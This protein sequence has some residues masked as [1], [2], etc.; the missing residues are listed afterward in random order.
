MRWTDSR[1]RR[2]LIVPMLC[3]VAWRYA[4]L[5]PALA[6]ERSRT[7]T[8]AGAPVETPSQRWLPLPEGSSTDLKQQVQWL[9]QLKG[10]L[11]IGSAEDGSSAAP[12]YD[13]EQ[14]KAL[15][16]AMKPL[17]D[18]L[19]E[20]LSSRKLDGRSAEQLSKMMAD[21][22]MQEQVRRLLEQFS[23][24]GKPLPENAADSTGVPFPSDS[25]SPGAGAGQ[26][27]IAVPR[28]VQELM[29]RL[30]EQLG[31]QPNGQ[32]SDRKPSEGKLR[33]STL[34]REPVPPAIPPTVG[35]P[36]KPGS[37]SKTGERH[38]TNPF[39]P[40][41]RDDEPNANV[42]RS[43]AEREANAPESPDEMKRPPRL[44]EG[45]RKPFDG[46]APNPPEQPD[47]RDSRSTKPL[48]DEDDSENGRSAGNST[49][50]KQDVAAV[51]RA[52]ERPATPSSDRKRPSPETVR[53]QIP[54]ATPQTPNA[55]PNPATM[56]VRSELQEKGFAR[57]LR[58]IVEQARQESQINSNNSTGESADDRGTLK[59]S[60]RGLENSIVRM[61]DGFR[62]DLA[63]EASKAPVPSPSPGPSG[64]VA[65][66]PST[67][68]SR[69]ERRSTA[70]KV[71]ESIGNAFQEMA[72][73]P[74]TPRPASRTNGGVADLPA[75]GSRSTGPLLILLAALGLVW[76]FLP[77]MLTAF[78]K[79]RL[80][81]NSIG[82]AI[83][84]ADVRTREDVV[85]AFHKYALHSAMSAP[86]WWTHREVERR[87]SDT[88][89]AL[90]PS[91]QA[92]ANLYEQARYLPGDAEFT[93]DQLELARRV[94]A[95]VSGANH[96]G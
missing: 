9:L 27:P 86:T 94:L 26:E 48:L 93:P 38:R 32:P 57:T 88:A 78:Q 84:A 59:G 7:G 17:T 16:S 55:N 1:C 77:R 49:P 6:Q 41:P 85:R 12:P 79:S 39:G 24:T 62:K 74:A 73:A 75:G 50:G 29:K 92:L 96:L 53:P 19:P 51:P 90:R 22:A 34:D 47:P 21:P 30:T 8:S 4:E 80:T 66:Q 71:F 72:S 76:H 64:V 18:M 5:S 25:L 2:T 82:D 65:P 13:P 87:V 40:E 95:N 36:K 45:S 37:A 23:K 69:P 42:G 46:L 81:R 44:S 33:P 70:G 56:D 10:L 54:T 3:L 58:K 20:G 91:I 89:P 52:V 67:P 15:L 11:A 35:N 83:P 14:L 28:S 68:P 63:Q 60:F 43:T 61:L 31:R